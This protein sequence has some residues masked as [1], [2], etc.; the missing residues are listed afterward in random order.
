MTRGRAEWRVKVEES[1]QAQQE[2]AQRNLCNERGLPHVR[3][4]PHLK[5]RSK[6]F[7]RVN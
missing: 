5:E 6:I 2:A 4:P 7:S 1:R 3:M